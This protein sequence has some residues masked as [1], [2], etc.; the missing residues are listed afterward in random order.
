MPHQC[1]ICNHQYYT[2]LPLNCN[3][4]KFTICDPCTAECEWKENGEYYVS[5]CIRCR[6]KKKLTDIEILYHK[7]IY[8]ANKNK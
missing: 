8:L 7:I 2:P 5:F 6:E 1:Y 3:Q 4:C